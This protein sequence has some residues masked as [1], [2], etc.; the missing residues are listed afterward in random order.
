MPDE[1]FLTAFGGSPKN[2]FLGYFYD[3]ST[4]KKLKSVKKNNQGVIWGKDPR[5][6]SGMCFECKGCIIHLVVEYGMH[7]CMSCD[8]ASLLS[9]TGKLEVL[10][11]IADVTILYS[12]CT[13]KLFDHPNVHWIGHV[14]PDQ[15]GALLAE[16]KFLLGMF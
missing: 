14:S 10:K 9:R 2:S 7:E 12:T 16:S 6:Y 4:I 11:A 1:R 15:W 8:S 5:H 13:K 3:D